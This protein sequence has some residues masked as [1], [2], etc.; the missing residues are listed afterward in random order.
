MKE[1]EIARINALYEELDKLKEENS[2][3]QQSASLSAL[4]EKLASIETKVDM[5][6]KCCECEPPVKTAKKKTK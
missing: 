3:L 5:I 2:R 4:D 1:W 6:C